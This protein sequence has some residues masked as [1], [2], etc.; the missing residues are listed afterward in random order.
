MRS[1]LYLGSEAAVFSLNLLRLLKKDED[2]SVESFPFLEFSSPA[3]LAG[4]PPHP[5]I[6][7]KK[8]IKTLINEGT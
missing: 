4:P 1:S 2:L 3:H 6:D 5:N 7:L 8:D